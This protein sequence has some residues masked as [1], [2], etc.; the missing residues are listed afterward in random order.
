M[1]SVAGVL[2]T[3]VMLVIILVSVLGNVLVVLSVLLVRALRKPANILLVALAVTDLLVS[4]IVMPGAVLHHLIPP[5]SHA[6]IVWVFTDV[7]LCTSSILSL[8]AICIDRYLAISR[9]LRYIPIRTNRSVH[10]KN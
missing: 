10:S 8:T 6:C 5:T 4:I 2:V 7:F 3:L 1:A 9:P